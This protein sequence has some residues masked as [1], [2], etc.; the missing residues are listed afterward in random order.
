MT[1]SEDLKNFVVSFFTSLKCNLA[2]DGN[3]LTVFN[4]PENFQK[5][6]GKASP[7]QIVFLQEHATDGEEVIMKGSFLLNSIKEFLADKGQTTLVKIDFE[8][9]DEVEIKNFFKLRNATITNISKKETYDF[10]TRFTFLTNLQYLNEREQVMTPICVK[11]NQ[12]IDF[13]LEKYNLLAGKKDEIKT[14]DIKPQYL[15]AK[16]YLKKLIEPKIEKIGANL[17]IKLEKELQRIK[18]HYLNQIKEDGDNLIKSEKQIRELENQLNNPENK[19]LDQSFLKIRIKRLAETIENLNSEKRKAA[20]SAEEDFFN[21]DETNRHSLA[22]DNK[23]INTTIAYFPIFNY[24]LYL[25]N[26]DAMR[27]LNLVYNPL[28]KEISKLK[29]EVC[30][31]ELKDLWLCSTGHISCYACM[32]ACLDCGNEYC[33]N[34][35]KISCFVCEKQLCK[36]CAKKC[37]LCGKYKCKAHMSSSSTCKTCADKGKASTLRRSI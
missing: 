10:M 14:S 20:L 28:T 8:L 24:S 4:I 16:E 22:I 1:E 15:A 13:D 25:K 17:N 21:R 18:Q 23:V 7:Y 19:E 31:Q 33:K 11:E 27:I 5:F 26:H 12:I 35:L 2:W 3:K 30:S 37:N 6:S 32:K 9:N 34:C 36:K 29:C